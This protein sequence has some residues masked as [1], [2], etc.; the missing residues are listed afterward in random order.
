[1]GLTNNRKLERVIQSWFQT[2]STPVTWELF[3]KKL[4]ELKYMDL[5]RKAQEQQ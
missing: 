1:M 5:V 4:K 2:S 3:I